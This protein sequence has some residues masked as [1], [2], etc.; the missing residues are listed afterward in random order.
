MRVS[1][2]FDPKRSDVE[3]SSFDLTVMLSSNL[4]IGLAVTMFPWV[5]I[6]PECPE[7]V[8]ADR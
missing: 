8:V 1:D 5:V 2:I 3:R 4:S 6:H 7:S